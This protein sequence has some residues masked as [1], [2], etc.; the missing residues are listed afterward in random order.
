M[1]CAEFQQLVEALARHEIL[2]ASR[3]GSALV[4]AEQCPGCLH[5]LRKA[6]ALTAALHRVAGQ[7]RGI[8]PPPWIEASLLHAFDEREACRGGRLPAGGRRRW[9]AAAASVAAIGIALL[10]WGRG[11]DP[12]QLAQEPDTRGGEVIAS[13]FFPLG[14]ELELPADESAGVVRVALPRATLLAFGLPMN[15][16]LAMEPLEAEVL[17]GVDGAAQAIRFLHQLE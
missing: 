9:V 17:V 8:M 5:D 10:S 13:E 11:A 6:E 1:N 7:G 2:D 4:H 14:A 3:R 12:S 15:P 16:D